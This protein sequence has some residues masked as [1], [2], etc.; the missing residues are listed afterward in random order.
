MAWDKKGLIFCP[1]RTNG[2]MVSN[3]Q[4]P[5][6]L[7]LKDRIRLYIMTRDDNN[8]S[9]VGIVDLDRDDP[10]KIIEIHKEPALDLGVRGGFDDSGVAPSCAITRNNE[11]LLYYV[12]ITPR[13]TVSL[14]YSIGLA[15]SVNGG[16]TFK[17][18]YPGPIITNSA[19]EPFLFTSP[20]VRIDNDGWHMHYTSGTGWYEIEDRAEMLYDIKYAWSKD[21]HNW[22]REGRTALPPTKENEVTARP[23]I[24]KSEDEYRMWFCYRG[25]TDFRDGADSY[26]IGYAS[27][28]DGQNWLRDDAEAG[29]EPSKTGWDSAMIAY[30]AI[31]AVDDR[32]LLF[33]NGNGFG[34]TGVGYAVWEGA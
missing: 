22:V 32:L 23:W 4:L 12:G 16:K 26:R 25:S 9:R 1:D 17:R 21:G 18:V 28:K 15:R 29:I 20:F 30:P 34:K 14:D 5:T 19:I 13:V 10:G 31:L 3:A 2:W 24:I 8:R 33:Y 11:I 6:P 7:L 27:S